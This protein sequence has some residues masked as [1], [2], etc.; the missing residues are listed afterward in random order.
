MLPVK[1]A[2][3]I[4]HLFV[5]SAFKGKSTGKNTSVGPLK[6]GTP[7][8]PYNEFRPWHIGQPLQGIFWVT[9]TFL[10]L[11]FGHSLGGTHFRF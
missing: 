7:M 4:G 9:L 10:G 6:R 5:L 11:P 2:K 3:T 8:T 1:G